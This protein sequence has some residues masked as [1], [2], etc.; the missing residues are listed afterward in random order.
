MFFQAQAH[1]R[2]DDAVLGSVQYFIMLEYTGQLILLL[3]LFLPV[4]VR[5]SFFARDLAHLRE[6]GH[7]HFLLQIIHH[8]SFQHDVEVGLGVNWSSELVVNGVLVGRRLV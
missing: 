7:L 5:D 2:L 1:V 3:L 4:A 6:Q 8:G